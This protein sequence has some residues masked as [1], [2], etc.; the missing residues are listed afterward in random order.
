MLNTFYQIHAGSWAIL[1]IL[2]IMSYMLNKQEFTLWG[3]RAFY[4]LMLG[5][6][7]GMV[8]IKNFPVISMIKA[9][10]ALILIMSMEI[11]VARKRRGQTHTLWWGC[12]CYHVH[13][14]FINRISYYIK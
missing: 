4:V 9:V 13:R 6:G 5:S 14:Y 2:F 10:F 3:Q 8:V 11:L 12:I 1:I 7:I